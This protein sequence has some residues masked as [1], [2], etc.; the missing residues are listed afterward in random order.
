MA[1]ADRTEPATPRR[2]EKAREKGQVA[3]SQDLSSS[4]ALLGMFGLLILAAGFTT[5]GILAI[6]QGLWGTGFYRDFSPGGVIALFSDLILRGIVIMSPYLAAAFLLSLIASLGQVGFLFSSDPITPKLERLN[7]VEGIKRIFSIRGAFELAKNLLKVVLVG[8]VGFL[9]LKAN[10]KGFALLS[11]TDPT[12]AMVF[13]GTIAIKMGLAMS[14]TLVILSIV[15]YLYQ[16]YEYEKSLRMTKYEVK[17]E[18]RELEGD[19]LIKRRIRE[20]GRELLFRRQL[21]RVREADVV[22]TNPEHYAVAL[23]YQ[24]ERDAPVVVAKGMDYRALKIIEMAREFRVP[25]HRNPELARALYHQVEV[26]QAI[27][28]EFFAAV[29][30]VLALV[31]RTDPKLMRK[32]SALAV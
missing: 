22:I 29:A 18:R 23:L 25:L 17:Q 15:D 8:A 2:K 14:L 16:R 21:G 1:D 5:A 10:L 4:I 24:P 27:P 28:P 9:M 3:R 13:A 12:E 19:P 32:L 31:A 7:P 26:D 30:E 20:L 6:T 11:F